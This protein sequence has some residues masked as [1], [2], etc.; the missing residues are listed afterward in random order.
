MHLEVLLGFLCQLTLGIF[1]GIPEAITEEIPERI[2]GEILA[3]ILERVPAGIPKK[4]RNLKNSGEELLRQS[5]EK[6][7]K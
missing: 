1:G 7:Q 4:K 6:T 2:S 3:G 5:M